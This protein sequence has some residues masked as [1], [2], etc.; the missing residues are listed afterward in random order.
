M[1]R[2]GSDERWWWRRWWWWWQPRVG[3]SSRL[4]SSGVLRCVAEKGLEVSLQGP[5][6][7]LRRQGAGRVPGSGAGD[8]LA[9]TA[10]P[11]RYL[12][13]LTRLSR[14]PESRDWGEA[15]G[16]TRAHGKSLKAASRYMLTVQTRPSCQIVDTDTLIKIQ[17]QPVHSARPDPAVPTPVFPGLCVRTH[18]H[19]PAAIRLLMP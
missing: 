7:A 16:Q 4:V 11:T 15:R 12:L 19:A 9:S 10:L 1:Q 8:L 2:A 17:I 18:A 14:P 3:A 5:A 6:S 13:Y